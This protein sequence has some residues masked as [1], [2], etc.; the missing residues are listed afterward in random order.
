MTFTPVLS[1][2]IDVEKFYPL[3]FY[4]SSAV[5]A[6]IAIAFL[7]FDYLDDLSSFTVSAIIFSVFASSLLI[8]TTRKS[9]LKA[10]FFLIAAGS[11]V[12]FLMYLMASFFPETGEII[13]ILMISAGLFSSI[14]YILNSRPELV[15]DEKEAKKI[16]AAMATVV[17]LLIAYNLLFVEISLAFQLDDTAVLSE[18]EQVVGELEVTKTGYL[19][20]D[21]QG[22][23]NIDF[24]VAGENGILPTGFQSSYGSASF[25]F[26]PG[27]HT[28]N[29]TFDLR[30]GTFEENGSFRSERPE[31]LEKNM[32]LELVRVEDCSVPEL[33]EGQLG[34]GLGEEWTLQ[35]DNFR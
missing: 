32:E 13:V 15:P 30:D 16:I 29:L 24:C 6:V 1:I 17:G 8:A 34:V 22:E 25:G 31:W 4:G 26:T 35:P 27:V 33:E 20:I 12:L 10:V 28:E 18:E 19:P 23:R 2:M 14:G 9:L 7:G 5:F 11:Y 3:I 21:Y